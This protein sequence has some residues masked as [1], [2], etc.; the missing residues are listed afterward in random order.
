M[1][2][3]Q[4]ASG[5]YVGTQAEAKGEGQGWAPVEVPVSKPELIEW[6]NN[7]A[8]P[9]MAAAVEPETIQVPSA[10]AVE[11]TPTLPKPEPKSLQTQVPLVMKAG[12]VS[13][14][15]T[16]ISGN[17]FGIVLSAVLSRLAELRSE[18]WQ[19]LRDA[20]RMH[21]SRDSVERGI[22]ILLLDGGDDHET[23]GN[24]WK[25]KNR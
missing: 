12:A 7:N 14:Y 18:G 9:A 17:E 13:D 4:T 24:E 5:M 19:G 8:R 11:E 21:R 25:K 15:I 23:S 20:L 2:L 22:G 3:Y 10:E 16:E 1:K 6:L